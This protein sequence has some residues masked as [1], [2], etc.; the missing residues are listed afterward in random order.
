VQRHSLFEDFLLN[1]V[2]YPAMEITKTKQIMVAGCSMGAYHAANFAFRHPNKVSHLFALSG[3]YDMRMFLDDY[4]DENA[5]FNNPIDYLP[6][7]TNEWYLQ[8]INRMGI[9]IGTAEHDFCK[10]YS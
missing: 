6:N 10:P 9:V 4:F 3:A 5:Y 1:E 8:Y 7:L 2:V